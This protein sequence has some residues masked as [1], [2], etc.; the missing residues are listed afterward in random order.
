MQRPLQKW[1]KELQ[2]VITKLAMTK[3][4]MMAAIVTPIQ[5]I[6]HHS[7]LPTHKDVNNKCILGANVTKNLSHLNYAAIKRQYQW[8][9][10]FIWKQLKV[11]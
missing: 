8:S 7:L 2:Q 3:Y 1:Y 9:V 5:P 10:P 11:Q 4:R 6:N